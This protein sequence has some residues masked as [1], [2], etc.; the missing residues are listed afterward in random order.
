[1]WHELGTTHPGKLG[2][3]AR[4]GCVWARVRARVRIR[5]SVRIRVRVRVR[6]TVRVR[7]SV[8]VSV[9]LGGYFLRVRVR[10][11]G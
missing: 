11:E 9:R 7:V 2:D 8:R 3:T 6:V 5:V 4:Q 1:M 10:V